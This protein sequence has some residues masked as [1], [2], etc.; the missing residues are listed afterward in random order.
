MKIDPA[1]LQGVM[2]VLVEGGDVDRAIF[3][4]VQVMVILGDPEQVD[5]F[6][7]A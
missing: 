2:H 4:D 5:L 6:R 1:G 3:C 7:P